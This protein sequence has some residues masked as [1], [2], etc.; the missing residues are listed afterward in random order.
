MSLEV[1]PP[2][3]DTAAPRLP[4]ATAEQHEILVLDYHLPNFVPGNRATVLG[5]CALPARGVSLGQGRAATRTAAAAE[6]QAL[7]CSFRICTVP[8]LNTLVLHTAPPAASGQLWAAGA[9]EG[10]PWPCFG[11]TWLMAVLEDCGLDCPPPVPKPLG[12]SR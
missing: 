6:S 10:K 5:V 9:S 8:T 1:P 11:G 4:L 2:Q 7:E 3:T 12:I